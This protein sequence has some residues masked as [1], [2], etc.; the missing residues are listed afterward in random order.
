MLM[1]P[2]NCLKIV[3]SEQARFRVLYV[4]GDA[5]FLR[6]LREVLTKP[7][8]HIVSCPDVGSAID[9]LNGNPRYDLLI[10]ELELRGLELAKLARS[11]SHRGHLPIVMVTANEVVGGFGKRSRSSG[12][13]EWV[14]KRDLAAQPQVLINLLEVGAQ[15]ELRWS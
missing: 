12:V 1:L 7:E 5:E 6:P 3:D 10:F 14:S 2:H 4:G 9:F 15:N 13:D 8:Y 11:L